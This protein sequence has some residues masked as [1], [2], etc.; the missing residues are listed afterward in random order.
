MMEFVMRPIG[1]IHSPFT[2]KNHMP[3]QSARSQAIGHVQVDQQFSDG[4]QDIEGFS[5]LILLYAFHSSS[6][7][8]LRVK[9]FLDDQIRGL[10]STRYPN[11]PNPIGLSVVELVSRHDHVL[12]IQGVDVL[13]GTPL[14]DI[15]PYV[16]EFDVR[17]PAR[18]G[19]LAHQRN[20]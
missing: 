19:W 14:L 5:H 13:D 18:T 20:E 9:P 1:I 11:R 16:P 10:F 12:E 17:T 15:K 8:T 6:G 2:D 4:L 7:Y 3:I